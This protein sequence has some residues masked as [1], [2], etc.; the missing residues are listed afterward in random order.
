MLKDLNSKQGRKHV[1][2]SHV[3]NALE[4][5]EEAAYE[6]CQVGTKNGSNSQHLLRSAQHYLDLA[7]DRLKEIR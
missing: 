7:Q 5:M 4:K 1:S 6:L 3:K 2:L